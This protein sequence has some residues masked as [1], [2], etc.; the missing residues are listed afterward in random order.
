MEVNGNCGKIKLQE[1]VKGCSDQ[2]E[3]SECPMAEFNVIGQFELQE[4]EEE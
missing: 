1:Q 4:E 3:K 2:L